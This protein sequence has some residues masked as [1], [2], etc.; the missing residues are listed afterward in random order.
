MPSL[1]YP[2][3][4]WNWWS[5]SLSLQA[6]LDNGQVL[7]PAHS[8][9]GP[10]QLER[11]LWL[12]PAPVGGQVLPDGHQQTGGPVLP[13]ALTGPCCR[14]LLQLVIP[15]LQQEEKQAPGGEGEGGA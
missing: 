9:G 14:R 4:G 10:Q 3:Y 7:S 5:L 12:L 13:D 6:K 1:S 8:N 11:S 15:G 2:E